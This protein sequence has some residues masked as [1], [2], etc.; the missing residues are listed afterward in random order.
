M[1]IEAGCLF[2]LFVGILDHPFMKLCTYQVSYSLVHEIVCFSIF[3]D[4]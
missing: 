4:G 3:K 1:E 2:M